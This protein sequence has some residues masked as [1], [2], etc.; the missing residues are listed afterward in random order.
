MLETQRSLINPDTETLLT[1]AAKQVC[2]N[3]DFYEASLDIYG[4]FRDKYLTISEIL[5]RV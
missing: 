5:K 4:S 1:S 2:E 3:Q